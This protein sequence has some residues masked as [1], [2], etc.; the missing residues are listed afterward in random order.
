MA[1]AVARTP[2]LTVAAFVIAATAAFSLAAGGVV[3]APATPVLNSV[4]QTV[5]TGLSGVRELGW[6]LR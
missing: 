2:R 3:T 1:T 5:T 4:S 6:S